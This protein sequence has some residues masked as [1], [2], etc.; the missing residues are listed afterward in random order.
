[1]LDF[2]IATFLILGLIFGFE[3]LGQRIF[4]VPEGAGY[5]TIVMILVWGVGPVIGL[6]LII[7][8]KIDGPAA[9]ISALV[10]AAILKFVW[11]DTFRSQKNKKSDQIQKSKESEAIEVEA[12]TIEI[13]K[14]KIQPE[15]TL[16]AS[17]KWSFNSHTKILRNN[18]TGTEYPAD[19]YERQRTSDIVSGF[20]ILHGP[21]V[22]ANDW[23]VD[24]N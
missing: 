20:Q 3:S 15:S 14:T 10:Y 9:F 12:E 5:A 24:F 16:P 17:K 2:L 4:K 19:R 6:L 11:W 23:D 7:Q 21:D 8:G 22:W 18:H 1:M 13:I